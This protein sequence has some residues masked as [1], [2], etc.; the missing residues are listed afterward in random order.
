MSKNCGPRLF[1]FFKI[2]LSLIIHF[3]WSFW[4]YE[5]FCVIF[6]NCPLVRRDNFVSLGTQCDAVTTAQNPASYL[7]YMLRF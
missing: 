3:R 5:F 4:M 6:A 2:L 1:S 7:V